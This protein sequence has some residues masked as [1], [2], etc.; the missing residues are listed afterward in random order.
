MHPSIW[1]KQMHQSC[2]ACRDLNFHCFRI[3]DEDPVRSRQTLVGG[4]GHLNPV[5]GFGWKCIRTG[6]LMKEL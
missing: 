5:E 1:E 6:Y 3:P 4:P 2:I